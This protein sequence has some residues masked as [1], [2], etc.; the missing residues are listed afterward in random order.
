[1]AT[2]CDYIGLIYQKKGRYDE[3]MN[4]HSKAL[5]I[6]ETCVGRGSKECASSHFYVAKCLL[7][8]HEYEECIIRIRNHLEL[9]C[10][11]SCDDD[12]L[13]NVYHTLGLAQN[14]LGD[15]EESIG[16]LN[17]VLAIRTKLNG[18]SSLQVAETLLDMAKVL[19]ESGDSE[20]VSMSAKSP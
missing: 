10:G 7:A 8:S 6:H 17:R 1:M 9:F 11:E 19:E 18:K 5:H 16:S 20:Q 3:S 13:S 15:H 14:A 4:F 2:P 12:E